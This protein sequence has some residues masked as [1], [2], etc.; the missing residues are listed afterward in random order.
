MCVVKDYLISRH[1]VYSL[2]F[3]LSSLLSSHRKNEVFS[4]L[5]EQFVLCFQNWYFFFLFFFVFIPLL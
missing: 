1:T 2:V 3:Y 4:F 5:P